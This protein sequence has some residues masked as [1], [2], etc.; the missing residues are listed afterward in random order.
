MQRLWLEAT[1]LGLWLQPEMTP[2][3]F[4]RYNRERIAFTASASGRE[5]AANIASGFEALLGMEWARRIV[6]FARV[7]TGNAPRARSTRIPL[8]KLAWAPR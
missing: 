5:L 8:S 3:I 6:F 1:R 2:V 7:G 4:G